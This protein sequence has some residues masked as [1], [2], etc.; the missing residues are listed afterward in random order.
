MQKL[1]Q[2][3][4]VADFTSGLIDDLSVSKAL[5]PKNAVRKAINVQFHR[6]RGNVRQR[7]GTT[8]LGATV[9]AGNTITGLFN[10]RSSATYHQL[11]TSATTTIY[12]LE[13]ASWT[14]TV[15]GLTSGLKTRFITYVDR[16][17]FM[18]GTDQTQSWDGN[19]A[20]WTSGGG[21]LDEANF[22][23][24]KFATLL[25]GRILVAGDPSAPS[26]ISLSSIVASNA[27][28]WTSGNKTVL[29]S[30]QDGAGDITGVTGN[31]R[32][33]LI[34][35]ERGLYRYD[36]NELQ[37]IGYVGT[38]SYESIATD[39]NGITYF[40][41]QG[42]NGVG[43]YMTNGG[44]PVK[45][46]RKIIRYVEAISPSFYQH[47]SSYT[48]G[49]IVEWSVGSITI[50][51]VTYTNASIVYC[52]SDKTWTIY[53]R[54]DRFRVF[55]QY[56]NGSSAVTTVAGDTDGMIQTID[57]GNTDNGSE[58]ESELEL[59]PI[60]FTTRGKTKSVS[61]ITFFTESYQ[62]LSVFIKADDQSYIP[63]GS[64][65]SKNQLIDTMPLIRG[66]EVY[67]RLT[68]LNLG[69]PWE[70]SGVEFLNNSIV[71][72]GYR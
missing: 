2:P 59:S 3:F 60:T 66:N 61:G 26:T 70:F 44:R 5:M 32:V 37:R 25:N 17:A 11:L 38:P 16:V 28:S 12:K 19:A 49:N 1:Q 51:S 6:P 15:S 34:F 8:K 24:A 54:A 69:D 21:R 22:P 62:G 48:D 13:G 20:A 18:N 4:V 50:E 45:I 47:V 33:S 63:L 68:G 39:D 31:G 27:I 42:A 71:D 56:I 35:K 43:F 9:S 65:R 7:L 36:D 29:V 57:S 14:S 55:A 58:I 30:P 52:I 72:E 10:F 40:F 53:N 41:G 23:K 64:L 46:S 67:I